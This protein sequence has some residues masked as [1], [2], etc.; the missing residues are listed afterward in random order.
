MRSIK[1]NGVTITGDELEGVATVRDL[2]E[3]FE[4]VFHRS[5][6]VVERKGEIEART[7]K[8]TFTTTKGKF[9]TSMK[10]RW[11]RI[12]KLWAG[13]DVN[14]TSKNALIF[15]PVRLEDD[16]TYTPSLLRLRRGDIFLFRISSKETETYLGFALRDHED[17]LFLPPDPRDAIIG[18][19]TGGGGVLQHLEPGD[20][21]KEITPEY[22]IESLVERLSF[23]DL[24]ED[25][26]EI[27]TSLMI[28]LSESSPRSVESFLSYLRNNRGVLAVDEVTNS[29]IR[30]ISPPIFETGVENNRSFRERGMV[31]MRNEGERKGSIY[32]YKKLRMPQHVMN[33]IGTITSGAELIDV[34]RAGDT[35]AVHTDP[36]QVL[37]LGMTQIEAE[38]VLQEA[39]I[40][41]IRHGDT[42]DDAIVVSQ[43]PDTTIDAFKVG[44]VET[45]G[46]PPDKIIKVE[47]FEEEAPRTAH[48]LKEV[49]G[50][51]RSHLVGRFDI[52]TAIESLVLFRGKGK[53]AVVKPENTPEKGFVFEEG[54]IGV[55]NM[56]L[57]QEGAIGVRLI[58]DPTF[59]PTGEI[60]E[61]TNIVGKV[62]EGL[63]ILRGMRKGR[64][65]FLDV[66]P[67]D[68]E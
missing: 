10:E 20:I 34:A 53:K 51:Y 31:F 12:Y 17:Q 5:M 50:L 8:Y 2:L 64:V 49:T 67:R 63:E 45:E 24:I 62:K 26:M 35:I 61:S 52:D 13:K 44:V 54:I 38:R 59:G 68:E 40:Q 39:G 4:P 43:K 11:H 65:Y 21:I 30:S 48:Y 14:I 42:A 9:S 58:E 27:Y 55:T 15:S 1:L 6:L 37:L 32:I 7:D 56:T 19:V 23:T 57:P 41:H 33:L 25:G 3:K 66:T 18:R 16:E 22:R 46:I 29:Y 28:K 36:V 47:L 60:G